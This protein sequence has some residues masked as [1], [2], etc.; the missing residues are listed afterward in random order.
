MRDHDIR[1]IVFQSLTV[2]CGT[3]NNAIRDEGDLVKSVKR[4]MHRSPNT[5]QLSHPNLKAAR[6]FHFK[7]GSP[8]GRRD[9]THQGI[10][11][12]SGL[13]DSMI[14]TLLCTIEVANYC[15]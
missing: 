9:A 3:V 15:R 8:T 5:M 14:T 4:R 7:S 13:R 11:L 10:N 6:W 12:D 1:L 2:G